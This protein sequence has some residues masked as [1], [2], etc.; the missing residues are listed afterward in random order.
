[1]G[2]PVKLSDCALALKKR[3]DALPLSACLEAVGATAG[4]KRLKAYLASL[5]SPRFEAAGEPGLFIKIDA[6]GTRTEGR[7][8]KR[9]FRPVRN[10]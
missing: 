3:G 1:M 6:D 2:Q 7:F 9:A 5:P 8:V 10:R 4:E